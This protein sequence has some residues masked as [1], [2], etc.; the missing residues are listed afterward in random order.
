[1]LGSIITI[2]TKEKNMIYLIVVAY[3]NAGRN[4][5]RNGGGCTSSSKQQLE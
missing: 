3:P 4:A 2:K 1:M 5:S